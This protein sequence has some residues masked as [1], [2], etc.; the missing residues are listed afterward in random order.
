MSNATTPS[1]VEVRYEHSPNFVDILSQLNVTLLFSTYQAGKL[2]AIG[3]HSGSIAIS[4]Y[5]F[6]Q[7]MG[8]AVGNGKIAVGS[9]RQ[10][11]FLKSAPELAARIEPAGKY[12]ACYLTRSCHY[13][14]AILG[15][16][17]AWAGDELWVV[18]TLFSSLCTLH[19]DFSFVPS[20]ELVERRAAKDARGAVDNLRYRGVA[21]LDVDSQT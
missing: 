3:S 2:F 16:E 18:N 11:W 20:D 4:F 8:V 10:I 7:A 1:L 21:T 14:G 9:K 5:H 17:L 19:A 13:T 12:D 15:H 6:D